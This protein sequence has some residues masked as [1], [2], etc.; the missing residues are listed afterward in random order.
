MTLSDLSKNIEER[1]NR[2]RQQ[3]K[4]RLTKHLQE[5]LPNIVSDEVIDLSGLGY[6]K[7]IAAD[8]TL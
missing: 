2:L 6:F 7:D 5:K 1:I 3:T 4:A 8:E